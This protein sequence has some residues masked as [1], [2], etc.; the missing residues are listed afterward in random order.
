MSTLSQFTGGGSTK[1]IVN[2]YSSGGVSPPSFSIDAT[3]VLGT[4]E[5]L[6]GAVT[7]NTLK[8][9]LTVSQ[10]GQ[11]PYLSFYSKN[12]TSR[13]VRCV[14][15]ADG[16]TVYDATTPAIATGGRGYPVAFS[17]TWNGAQAVTLGTPLRWA[18]SLVIQ[19]AS[20]LTETDNV[21]IAYSLN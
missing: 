11:M 17:A 4:R 15:V 21:A 9:L 7:A 1:A 3:A 10:A 20:S 13:T 5:V 12:S 14:I 8:T 18:S 16:V 19:V 6:S 2:A